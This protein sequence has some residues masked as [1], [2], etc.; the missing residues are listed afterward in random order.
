MAWYRTGT[1]ALTNGNA[2]VTGTGTAWIANASVGEGLIAPDGR[3]YEI[4]DIP[5]NT[6]LTISP[7]YLG[8]TASGQ[9]YAI[10][11]LR[12]RI[13]DLL[14]ETASLLASFATVRD[15]IGSGLFPNGTAA[16]PALRAAADQD[17]G[18]FFPAANAAAVGTGGVERLRVDG[19]GNV[20]VGTTAPSTLLSLG[21]TI[22][23]KLSVFDGFGVQSGLGVDMSGSGFELSFFSGSA[24]GQGQFAFGSINTT[25]NAF[26]E[27]L[28]ITPSGNV[29]IG[30]SSL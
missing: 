7:A 5:S 8:S 10:A 3:V 23:R 25:T 26:T 17:T 18:L 27:R 2:T 13:A 11:P 29:G 30:T 20:G 14:A 16:A 19:S 12:G 28:R 24:S 6:S 21:T 9:G 15:G 1:V 22:G 4:I